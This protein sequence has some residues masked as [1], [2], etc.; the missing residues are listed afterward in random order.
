MTLLLRSALRIVVRKRM[1]TV[2]LVMLAFIATLGLSSTM[3]VIDNLE[4]SVYETIRIFSG[5]VLI[6]GA[7][8]RGHVEALELRGLNVS[9]RR[10]IF[11]LIAGEERVPAVFLDR[12]SAEKMF[13]VS[14]IDGRMPQGPREALLYTS[15]RAPLE[16]KATATIGDRIGVLLPNLTSGGLTQATLEIVGTA[17]GLNHIGF[18]AQIVVM[19]D[20]IMESLTGG[21][22][23][24]LAVYLNDKAS[25]AEL[26]DD[27]KTRGADV[28]WYF[29]NSPE[30]NAILIILEGVLGL[31]TLPLIMLFLSAPMMTVAA[32]S[33]MVA[34][35]FKLI[36]IMKVMGVRR[37]ELFGHYSLP[38]VIR[39]AVGAL[40]GAAISPY[41]SERLYLASFGDSEIASVLYEALG[42]QVRA[43]AVMISML[44]VILSTLLASLA[45]FLIALRVNPTSAISQAGLYATRPAGPLSLLK[46][47]LW[48]RYAVRDLASR[49]WK[50]LALGALLSV[51]LGLYLASVAV[52]RSAEAA[53]E[54]A[55]R[56]ELSPAETY[57]RVQLAEM[58]TAEDV[59]AK[60]GALLERAGA[61]YHLSLI[62]SIPRAVEGVGFPYAV[63]SLDGDPL[64]EFPLEKGS[65]PTKEG[66]VVISRSLSALLGI[67][68]GERLAVKSGER[69]V[70][71]VVVGISKAIHHSGSYLLMTEETF[72]K[73]TGTKATKVQ[74]LFIASSLNVSRLQEALAPL[75]AYIEVEDRD[76]LARTVRSASLL[77]RGAMLTT[78]VLAVLSAII[79][80]GA[81]IASDVAVRTRELAV[82]KALGYPSLR[83]AL[84]AALETI[85]SIALFLPL[86]FLLAA[87]I[88][89]R[90]AR[91][92]ATFLPYIEPSVSPSLAL[93][94]GYVALIIAAAAFTALL[95]IA[96]YRRIGVA[97]ALSDI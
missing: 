35:D 37:L 33:A 74:S 89:D 44:I 38:W 12:S 94:A 32:G 65:I 84:S 5:D 52:D 51:I 6:M 85:A 11:G 30:E 55:E 26:V 59:R 4:R 61:R 91:G 67:E 43:G 96:Q 27:L 71:L 3:I 64:F 40:V 20:E 10:A 19:D 18:T 73:I 17:R 72:E 36:G 77:A 80:I 58:M 9:A 14:K 88:S 48:A 69:E 1:E 2:A 78:S 25:A 95:S 22:Y 68:V 83:L 76:G 79:T 49:P 8:D 50:P 42:F 66:E 62:T 81:V 7:F 31:F 63:R 24:F 82:L 47:P 21:K 28:S 90:M 45:I 34:R 93:E 13:G 60:V 75:P 39:S 54:L 29:V 57:A 53:A 15:T 46:G 92:A 86:S 87:A 16:A 41:A 97:R 70:E 56:G 23:T